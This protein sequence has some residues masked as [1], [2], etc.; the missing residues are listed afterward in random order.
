MGLRVLM[1]MGR[2]V[3]RMGRV[4]IGIRVVVFATATPTAVE[5]LG[6]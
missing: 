4:V 2:V 5:V 1:A 3:R 6:A